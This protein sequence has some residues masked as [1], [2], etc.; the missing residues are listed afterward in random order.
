MF[1]P[2]LGREKYLQNHLPFCDQSCKDEHNQLILSLSRCS[3]NQ[4]SK[5][6]DQFR[7]DL[8]RYLGNLEGAARERRAN[9]DL[10]EPLCDFPIVH[11]ACVLGK[12]AALE[13]MINRGGFNLSTKC[14]ATGETALQRAVQCLDRGMG[15]PAVEKVSEVFSKILRILAASKDIFQKVDRNGFTVFHT[16][17]MEMTKYTQKF[18]YLK[19][20]LQQMLANLS[21]SSAE[22]VL[23]VLGR[24]TQ[25]KQNFVHILASVGKDS[26]GSIK[27]ILEDIDS[28]IV[29]ELLS[30]KDCLDETPQEIA[31]RTENHEL[32]NVFSDLLTVGLPAKNTAGI[33]LKRKYELLLQRAG[34]AEENLHSKRRE[35]EEI[36]KY[37]KEE[38][39]VLQKL[40][41]QLHAIEDKI[42]QSKEKMRALEM[43]EQK[44]E[45]ECRQLENV[46]NDLDKKAEKYFPSI[47]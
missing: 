40:E 20:Y 11:W 22:E 31:E 7:E 16:V 21:K 4:S 19:E 14:K 28:G 26:N 18:P 25:G 9:A 46:Y 33:S 6:M 17:A 12:H 5:E 43:R 30:G 24:K 8:D 45:K 3:N 10:E 47:G 27:K 44:C 38:N 23:K 1:F 15:S 29:H 39:V 34:E 32:A 42:K 35:K 36:R 41:E 2:S 37:K 13:E